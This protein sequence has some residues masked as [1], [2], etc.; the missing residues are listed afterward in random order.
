MNLPGRPEERRFITHVLRG[1]EG[2]QDHSW[3]AFQGA[4]ETDYRLR[5]F[6]SLIAGRPQLL[7]L[8]TDTST[9]RIADRAA[10]YFPESS[11]VF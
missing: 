1:G 4:A 5:P 3:F 7:H 11:A 9:L 2:I 6:S 8:A 10:G